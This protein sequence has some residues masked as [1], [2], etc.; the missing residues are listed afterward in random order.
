LWTRVVPAPAAAGEAALAAEEGG[1]ER[2]GG[3]AGGWRPAMAVAGREG[4]EKP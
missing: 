2:G 1:G 4:G 3:V